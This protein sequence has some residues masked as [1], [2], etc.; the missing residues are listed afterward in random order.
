MPGAVD[1]AA[2]RGLQDGAVTEYDPP[3]VTVEDRLL[4]VRDD[5]RT[6]TD[7]V[8]LACAA[9]L[10]AL[11][12]PVRLPASLPP[13][14]GWSGAGVRRYAA[15]ER[16]DPAEVFGRLVSVA[17]RFLDFGGVGAAADPVRAAG[18]YVLATYSLDAFNVVGYLWPNGESG[19]G[20]STLLA[21]VTQTAYLGQLILAGSSYPTLRDLADCGATLA[22]DD[23]EAVMDTRDR[24]QQRH[25][26]AGRQPPWETIAV[27]E[28]DGDKWVTRHVDAFCPATI[29]RHPSCP[30]RFS[31]HAAS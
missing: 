23:A 24:S 19:S 9:P 1:G 13:G 12:M 20:K 21:V 2:N 18:R 7:G 6:F 8:A 11:G 10:T 28:L 4:I 3:R 17:D 16:P 27:K 31:D 15:G 26:A 5:G 22:F 14:S 29:F 25:A 30:I